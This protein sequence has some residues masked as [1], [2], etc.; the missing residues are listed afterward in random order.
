MLTSAKLA[1]YVDGVL[2]ATDA[3]HA[4]DGFASLTRAKKTDVA[5]FDNPSFEF[6]LHTT[7]A[8]LVI[9]KEERRHLCPV[10]CIVVSDPVTAF[11]KAVS[12]L[13]KSKTNTPHIDSSVE[14]HPSAQ[15]GKN[16]TVGAYSIIGENA[17]IADNVVLGAN[18][19]IEPQV[20][21]G[22]A[23]C[24]ASG[25]MVHTGSQLGA[26]VVV[27]SG[28]IIGATPFNYVKEQGKWFRG[29][30][31]GGVIIDNRVHLGAN[32]VIDRGS[33]SDTYLFEGVCVDNLV[34]IAHDVIIGSNTAVA[35][36]AAIG[37]F[38]QIGADCIIGDAACIAANVHLVDNV[39]IT[40]MSSVSKSISKSGIYS[41]GTMVNE[42]QRWRRNA[43]RFKRLDD[44]ISK[45]RH[46][47]KQLNSN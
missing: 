22:Q 29:P 32:C 47:E 6:A 28:C 31:A 44:Y 17:F 11:T 5:C 23:T 4:I 20:H 3:N 43:A 15:I 40:G 34:R 1:D 16:V 13:S 10:D 45:L 42:H 24:I 2:H 41:S 39:V 37:A 18:T 30:D 46:L 33:V 26:E 25:V 27:D 14:I 21:I 8:A 36:C 7:S 19:L 12:L 9:L 35:G 38:A